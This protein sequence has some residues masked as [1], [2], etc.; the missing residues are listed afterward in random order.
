MELLPDVE[1]RLF[2][3][4]GALVTPRS[5]LSARLVAKRMD[6][7]SLSKL[8]GPYETHLEIRGF[9]VRARRRR[10]RFSLSTAIYPNQRAV[11]GM[12]KGST[13][14]LSGSLHEALA[15][16]EEANPLGHQKAKRA[17]VMCKARLHQRPTAR[18]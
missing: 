4:K 18:K 6:R 10:N 16:F 7:P 2:T 15:C 3:N 5:Q 12:L 1:G 17:M 14:S 9:P 11:F 8:I 13:L